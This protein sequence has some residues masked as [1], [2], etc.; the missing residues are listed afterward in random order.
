MIQKDFPEELLRGISG[1]NEQ[2]ITP[3][4]YPT[5]AAFRFDDYDSNRSD[6]YR[7]LSINWVDDE[8]A[9][10]TLLAQTNTRTNAPQFQGG[11]CRLSRIALHAMKTYFDNGHLA[12]ERRP[13][14]ADEI[15]GIVENKY[16]GNVLMKCDLSKQ[17][18]TNI[19]V[20]LAGLA[21][22]VIPRE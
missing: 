8:D 15:K 6:D 19:Q 13:I 16:H 21:G 10:S 18:I 17:A 5:Q 2:F 22:A 1:K 12:Y 9:V 3:E 4:G 20:T 11:Y 7:E 14:E